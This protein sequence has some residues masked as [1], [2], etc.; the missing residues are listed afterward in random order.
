METKKEIASG[1]ATIMVMMIMAI[2]IIIGS[3][4]LHTATMFYDLAVQRT[5]IQVQARSSQSLMQYGIACCR[6]I[7]DFKK[8]EKEYTYILNKWPHPASGYNGKII[9]IPQKQHYEIKTQLFKDTQQVAQTS[10]LL[11]KGRSDWK[12]ANF[13]G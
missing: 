6:V 9:I 2:L 7:D 8:K 4:A 10:C 11:C 12:I 1:S 3:T 5:Q 13:I